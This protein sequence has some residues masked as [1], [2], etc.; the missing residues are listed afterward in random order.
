MITKKIILEMVSLVCILLIVLTG[1]VIAQEV[2]VPFT[3]EI[4]VIMTSPGQTPEITLINLLAKR[5]NLEV[6]SDN[7]LVPEK[8]NGFKTLIMAIGGSGKGLGAAGVDIQGEV[9]RANALI[10]ACKEKGIKIIGMH[11]GG[12]VRRGANSQIMI[13]LITPNCDYVVVRSDGNK[14]GIFTKICSEKKIPLAEI[15]KT[16][17]LVDILKAVFQL[18]SEN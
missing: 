17:E 11:L 5:V 1:S 12:E 18:P 13:D 6:K 7:F 10:A 16:I 2:Q 14:D 8:L 4:P 3:A 15:E 9:E